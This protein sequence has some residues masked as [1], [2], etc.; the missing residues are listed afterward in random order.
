[1]V[2]KPGESST[3]PIDDVTYADIERAISETRSVRAAAAYLGIPR[4]T[5]RSKLSEWKVDDLI[6]KYSD[7]SLISETV[8]AKKQSQKYQ[9]MNRVERKSFREHARVENAVEVYAAEIVKILNKKKFVAPPR[10]KIITAQP[11]AII[12]WSDHHLNERVAIANNTFDWRVAGQRLRKHVHES[13]RLCKAYGIEHVFVAF[14]GDVLNSDRRVDELLSNAGNRAKATVLAVDLY[15]QALRELNK[16]VEVSVGSV[17]GNESRVG[18]FVQWNYESASDNYD[19]MVHEHLSM[20]LQDTGIHFFPIHDP[21]EMCVEIS[22][23]NCLFLHGHGALTRDIQKSVQAAKGRWLERN[24]KVDLLFWGHI[25]EAL[26]AD[27]YARSSSLVGSN[28]YAQKALNLNSRS[29]QNFYVVLPDS[30]FHGFKLDLQ[31]VDGVEGYNIDERLESYNTKSA[32][33]VRPQETVL[34]VVV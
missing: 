12:H 4:S 20:L 19:F 1:M 10:S 31:N 15:Q 27:T 5:L 29:S 7:G 8:R 24:V 34:R 32:L 6:H 16:H 26:V 11:G 18:Q 23:Q 9:D 28:E 25:H 21:G 2:T 17:T 3:P 22:G 13:I 33:K 30:G 14:T